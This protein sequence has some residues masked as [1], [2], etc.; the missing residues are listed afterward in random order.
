MSPRVYTFENIKNTPLQPSTQKIYNTIKPHLTER[1]N[2]PYNKISDK[3]NLTD[4]E[5]Y[6]KNIVRRGQRIKLEH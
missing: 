1:I 2:N 6:T 3:N 4:N 5:Q